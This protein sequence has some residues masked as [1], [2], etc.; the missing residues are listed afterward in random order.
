MVR[1]AYQDG[2]QRVTVRGQ[3]AVVIM[4]VEEFRAARSGEA[5]GTFRRIHAGPASR[6]A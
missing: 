2:P 6:S 5:S 1:H 3:D 4:S